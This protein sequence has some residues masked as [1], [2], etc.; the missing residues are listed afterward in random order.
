MAETWATQT[1]FTAGE[2]SPQLLGRTDVSKYGNGVFTGRDVIIRKHGPIQRR[3][4]TLFIAEAKDTAA[5][6]VRLV[7]FRFSNNEQ[8]VL[9]FGDQYV[10]FYRDRGQIQDTTVVISTM[11]WLLD[12]TSV[13]TATDHQL[14]IGD[15]INVV[16]VTPTTYDGQ[17][18]VVS[19]PTSTTLT[20]A[21]TPDPGA[22]VSGGRVETPRVIQPGVPIEKPTPYITADLDL[23]KFTQSADQLYL[24]HPRYNP[25]ILSRIGVDSSPDN[26]QLDSFAFQ[27][28]PFLPLRALPDGT[29]VPLGTNITLSALA[30]PGQ[31][32]TLTWDDTGQDYVYPADARVDA[33]GGLPAI[34]GRRIQTLDG[35]GGSGYFFWEVITYTSGVEADCKLLGGGGATTEDVTELVQTDWAL[36]SWSQTDLKNPSTNL[37]PTWPSVGEF[38][39]NRLWAASTELQP[40]TLWCTRSGDFRTFQRW[41]NGDGDAGTVRDIDGFERTIS[42]DQNNAIQWLQSDSQGLLIPTDGGLFLGRAGDSTASTIIPSDFNIQ[43]QNNDSVSVTVQPQQAGS[44]FLI[45]S[46][47]GRRLREQVFDIQPNRIQGIDISV[48]SEHITAEGVS[49]SALQ[50]ERDTTIWLVR[51]DGVLLGVTYERNE[52]VIGW[53]RHTIGG[54]FQG[55]DAQAVSCEIARNGVDDL[56]Y[57]AVKRTVNSV[58]V[59]NIEFMEKAFETDTPHE[60]YIGADAAVFSASTAADANRTEQ[61]VDNLKTTTIAALDHLEGELVDVTALGSTL[62]QVTVSG[63]QIVVTGHFD[64]PM[65]IGLPINGR[66]TTMYIIPE[67]RV[68]SRGK[69]AQLQRAYLNMF[70]SLGG[71]VGSLDNASR[72]PLFFRT[73]SMEM[74]NPPDL[75][76]GIREIGVESSMDRES[77]LAILLSEPQPFMLLSLNYAFDLGGA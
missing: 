62:P 20:Y 61:D 23:L 49:D 66:I 21:Q 4:G 13:T 77:Q 74:D 17:Y 7:P 22:Y 52:N 37:N 70:R 55:G 9:E 45:A 41:S 34:E 50:R 24:F 31:T 53:H 30:V 19:T 46:Q 3:S 51:K 65:V 63:N 47:S 38:H 27:D 43:R 59:Q 16:G 40:Q 57:L 44:I 35:S 68:D 71:Q 28:G 72:F 75:F 54:S 26:W 1:N 18:V 36:G 60:N 15:S 64:G 67:S 42:D 25:L 6:P 39:Q 32:V 73:P 69:L 8:Y 58:D 10:R 12:V 29:V 2:L 56:L 5:N 14:L 11:S 33:A 76:T 48:L